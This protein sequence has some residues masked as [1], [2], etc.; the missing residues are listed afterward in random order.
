MRWNSWAFFHG[1]SQ[2]LVHIETI[3]RPPF[4]F[5]NPTQPF[6][7]YLT[8]IRRVFSSSG[9]WVQRAALAA[10]KRNK[11]SKGG[12]RQSAASASGGSPAAPG[13]VSV[14]SNSKVSY[15]AGGDL[16]LLPLM[17]FVIVIDD[18]SHKIF[19]F[20]LAMLIFFF[21]IDFVDVVETLSLKLYDVC[22]RQNQWIRIFML[23][24]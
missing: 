11:G 3:P 2:S 21:I 1:V 17:F 23:R 20:K 19:F 7:P 13:G 5:T 24:A 16:F 15:S 8:S 18:R 9:P 6:P 10:S 12:T 4:P 22:C 14:P